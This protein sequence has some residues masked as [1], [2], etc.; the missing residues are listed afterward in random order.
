MKKFLL[1]I[2]L[3]LGCGL[4]ADDSLLRWAA[5]SGSG[6]PNVFYADNDLLAL[7]GFEKDIIEKIAGIIGRRAVFCQNDWEVLI[8]GLQRN[9]YDVVIN[10]IVTSEERSTAVSFSIPYY[11]CPL[12]LIIRADTEQIK[13]VLDCN[14]RSVGILQNSKSE[15]ALTKNLKSVKIVNY[16]DEYSAI[17]DLK[18]GRIDAIILD[19]QIAAYYTKYLPN[20]K[21]MDEFEEVKYSIALAKGND[22]LLAEI[23]QAIDAM[24]KDGSLNAI[25]SK[26][27]IGNGSYAKLIATKERGEQLLARNVKETEK[28]KIFLS[29]HLKLVPFFAKAACITLVLSTLGMGVAIVFG[30]CFAVIREYGPKWIR[31]I[32]V[33]IIEFL[34]GTP[35]LIQ[36][37]FIFYGLPR[38]GITLSPIVA[39]ILTLGI[40]YASY[41]T[42]NFRAGMAAVPYG[43]MEAARALGMSQWQSLRHIILP[44]AFTFILPPLTNDFIALLKDSSLVSLIT[45][46]ELTKAYSIAASN[47]FDFFGVGIIVSVI[48]FLIGL[49]FVR[50]A[51]WAEHHMKLEKRAYASRKL[52]KM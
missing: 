10:G 51:R 45:I 1:A 30:I 13:S 3:L 9:L 12:S 8:P 18:N 42:E 48:Y 44:Q 22:K 4:S 40:N 6:A 43:Q 31:L 5:D 41:E 46:V 47:S 29:R 21:I 26:W 37:F 23:N 28:G 34:R 27:G 32:I 2:F 36:L 52:R 50:I 14:G 11:A 19:G 39:G 17:A 25:I 35:L 49:P 24:K 38:I 16:P 15:V 33:S 7:T 20:L